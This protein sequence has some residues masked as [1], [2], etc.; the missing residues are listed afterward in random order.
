M[1]LTAGD[2]FQDFPVSESFFKEKWLLFL[3]SGDLKIDHRTVDHGRSKK[4]N[5]RH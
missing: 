2:M 5:K 4:T 3:M 1:Y